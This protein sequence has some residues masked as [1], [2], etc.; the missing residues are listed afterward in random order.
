MTVVRVE[1]QSG[2]AL[3]AD[4][5]GGRHTVEIA[6]VEPIAPGEPLLVHAGVA[7]ASLSG[8]KAATPGPPVARRQITEVGA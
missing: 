4:A 5:G 1:G 7:I 3:C 6:L 2:L 8:N